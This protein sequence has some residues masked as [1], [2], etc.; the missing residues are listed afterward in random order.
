V[1]VWCD[2]EKEKNKRI[3]RATARHISTIEQSEEA[4]QQKTK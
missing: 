2:H 3:L 4:K 1:F